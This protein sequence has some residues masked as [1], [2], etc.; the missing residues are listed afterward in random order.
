MLLV[1]AHA[2]FPAFALLIIYNYMF[3]LGVPELIVIILAFGFL[4]FGSDK[5]S[6]FARS[7]GRFSGEFKKGRAEIDAELKKFSHNAEEEG[8]DSK[9]K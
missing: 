4:F 8:K 5:L 1:S 6:D 3:G 9:R 2:H 7:L